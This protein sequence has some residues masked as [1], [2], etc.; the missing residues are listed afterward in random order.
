[1]LWTE[2]AAALSF[3]FPGDGANSFLGNVRIYLQQ[4]GV[5]FKKIITAVIT[6]NVKILVFFNKA[7]K[8]QNF[9]LNGQ[10][11]FFP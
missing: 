3:A 4:Y 2:G 5:T 7:V 8:L 1:M 9:L 10:R 6:L 11:N